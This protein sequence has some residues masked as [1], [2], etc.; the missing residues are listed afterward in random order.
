MNQW[1]DKIQIIV[2]ED[3]SAGVNFEHWAIDGHTALRFVSD[4]FAGEYFFYKKTSCIYLLGSI[5][6]FIIFHTLNSFVF[7][8]VETVVTFAKTITNPSIPNFVHYKKY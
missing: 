8:F 4:V 7:C 6:L 3:G 5:F 2:C 1:Y